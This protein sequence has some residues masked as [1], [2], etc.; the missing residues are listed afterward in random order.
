MPIGQPIEPIMVSELEMLK[1]KHILEGK[2][3]DIH[4][5]E[6]YHLK[7]PKIECLLDRFTQVEEPH[8]H[9]CDWCVGG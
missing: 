7:V 8:F 2:I 9:T 1:A 4:G 5:S 3:S 6:K